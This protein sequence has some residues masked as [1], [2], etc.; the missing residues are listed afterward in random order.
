VAKKKGNIPTF[1]EVVDCFKSKGVVDEIQHRKFWNY[2]ESNGW[3]VGKN[4]MRMWRA[5]VSG[6]VT[7]EE[8]R[9]RV[10]SS[11]Q[12]RDS[13]TVAELKYESAK[14]LSEKIKHWE[15]CESKAPLEETQI[16]T[17]NRL[18]NE[19]KELTIE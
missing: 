7:R 14:V 8:E 19:L 18:R 15:E 16:K 6:W 10:P 4:K 11:T 13:K 17:L 12:T 1:N 3:M 5:A 9:R 2:Y